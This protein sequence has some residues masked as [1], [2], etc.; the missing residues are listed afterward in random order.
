M[1]QN[2]Y[3]SMPRKFRSE[4]NLCGYI[5]TSFFISYLIPNRHAC[6]YFS[7]TTER[8]SA[9]LTHQKNQEK[10]KTNTTH[11]SDSGSMFLNEEF[12]SH[13]LITTNLIFFY[14]STPV[15]DLIN[16]KTWKRRLKRHFLFCLLYKKMPL[17]NYY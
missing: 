17:I 1:A 4:F 13:K 16:G 10:L 12:L 15:F 7:S 11:D 8:F 6:V 2:T 14:N 3:L 9:V 5:V